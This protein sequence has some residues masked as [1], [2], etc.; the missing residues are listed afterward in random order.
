M[1]RIVFLGPPGAGKGTQA[2]RLSRSLDIV[3]LS[4][5][6]LLRSAVSER[7]NLGIE[8]DRYMRAGQLVPDE[9][10]IKVIEDN[11]RRPSAKT[12]FLLDG[13]PRTLRQAEALAIITPLDRVVS[14]EI[15]EEQLLERLTQRRSCPK[16][17]RAYNLAT[18]PP[19]VADHC[20]DDGTEL[21]QRPDDLPE[22][23]RTR[24]TV[25]QDQ[26]APLLAFYQRLGLLRPI[27]AAGDVD[28]VGARVR[29]A[30]A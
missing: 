1:H 9:L 27:N 2:T 13:F 3:H 15:P 22:A 26:T 16:C 23:V 5:G 20:D 25:Y 18:Q 19:R 8:A 14:F 6:D 4:T 21:V 30:T 28:E 10:V 29:T 11:L 24:L 7:T 17:A 12:G